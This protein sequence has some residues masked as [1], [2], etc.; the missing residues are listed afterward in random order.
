MMSLLS[1]SEQFDIVSV[2]DFSS[3]KFQIFRARRKEFEGKPSGG[4]DNGGRFKSCRLFE[5]TSLQCLVPE[6][7]SRTPTLM[8]KLVKSAK[9]AGWGTRLLG[10]R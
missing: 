5:K 4:E 9:L 10:C 7:A 2:S 8:A 3:L 6:V 1:A